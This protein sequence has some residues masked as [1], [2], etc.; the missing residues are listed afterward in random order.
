MLLRELSGSTLPPDLHSTFNSVS[1]QFTTDFFTSKQ[2]FALQFSG[3]F[4]PH[5]CSVSW[6]STVSLMKCI[7]W[8]LQIMDYSHENFQHGYQTK[9]YNT[10]NPK[11][12][13]INQQE[14]SGHE[15]CCSGAQY[16]FIVLFGMLMS[17]WYFNLHA[18]ISALQYHNLIITEISIFIHLRYFFNK[19]LILNHLAKSYITHT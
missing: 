1:L 6:P 15:N 5:I 10:C 8:K 18:I 9:Y 13:F 7:C 16:Y 19:N 17:P 4:F 3:V 14:M 2:G 11:A 12:E